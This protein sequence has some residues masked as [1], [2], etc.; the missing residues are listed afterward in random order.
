MGNFIGKMLAFP[1][2][3]WFVRNNW[4]NYGLEKVTMVKGFFFFKFACIEGVESV[5]RNVPW[6]IHGIPIFHNKWS[7]SVSLLKEELSHVPVWVKF[8]D[9]PLVASTSDRLRLMANKIVKKMKS[10]GKNGSTKNFMV[11]VKPNTQYRP[12]AKQSIEG[13]SNS[14]KTTP[15]VGTNKASTSGSKTTT[16]GTQDEGQSFTPIVNKISVLKKQILDGKLMFVNDDRK[17]LEKVDYMDNLGSNDEVEP[18]KNE[19]TCFLA[20]ILTPYK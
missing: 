18:V 14:P 16:S 7:P 4:E 20:S 10:G 2:I 19:M 8:H 3:E 15:F 1:V 13:T 11:S 6:M 5:L 12:K 9:V 17:P